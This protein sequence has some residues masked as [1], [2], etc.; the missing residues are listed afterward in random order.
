MEQSNIEIGTVA[1]WFGSEPYAHSVIPDGWE[2]CPPPSHTALLNPACLVWT[3]T[4]FVSAA[5]AEFIRK[6]Q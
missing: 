1:L 4:R 5:Q 2:R 3:G 6:V